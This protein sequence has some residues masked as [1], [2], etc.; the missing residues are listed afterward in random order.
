MFWSCCSLLKVKTPTKIRILNFWI[1]NDVKFDSIIFLW[2]SSLKKE[3]HWNKV[4]YFHVAFLKHLKCL[5]S[6]TPESFK[7]WRDLKVSSDVA[8][9]QILKRIPLSYLKKKKTSTY[10]PLPI[11]TSK[12]LRFYL[13][14]LKIE[15]PPIMAYSRF[16]NFCSFNKSLKAYLILYIMCSELKFHFVVMSSDLLCFGVSFWEALLCHLIYQSQLFFGLTEM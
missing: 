2:H 6:S 3:T 1:V 14:R 8:Y 5:Q 9:N 4:L 13:E 10:V 16:C 7:I 11:V 12:R 15:L